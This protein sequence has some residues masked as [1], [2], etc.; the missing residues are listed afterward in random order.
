M[1]SIPAGE[2]GTQRQE[3]AGWFQ[4]RKFNTLEL[5]LIFLSWILIAFVMVMTGFGVTRILKPLFHI[6]RETLALS[7]YEYFFFGFSI[8]SALAGVI[9]IFSS[10]GAPFFFVA[11]IFAL[12]F[13]IRWFRDCTKFIKQLF[14]GSFEDRSEKVIIPIALILVLSAAAH[15]ITLYDSGLYHEQTIK[16]IRNYPVIPGLGNIHGRLAFNSMFFVISAAFTIDYKDI[17]FYPLNSLCFLMLVRKLYTLYKKYRTSG[18][19]WVSFFFIMSILLSFVILLPDF[20]SPS[21]D[22][23]VAILIIYVFSLLLDSSTD[24]KEYPGIFRFSLIYILILNAVLYKLSSV[25]LVLVFIPVFR[26]FS[27]KKFLI[28]LFT[29]CI[30]VLP[31]LIRN[32]YL[33]GYLIYPFPSIDIFN[34]DWKIPLQNVIDEKLSIEN[35]AKIR[36]VPYQEVMG[37]KISEWGAVWLKS[38]NAEKIGMLVPNVLSIPIIVMMLIKKDYFPAAI[39]FLILINLVFWFLNA[40]DPRFVFGFLITGSSLV[41]SWF[42]FRIVKLPLSSLKTGITGSILIFIF[43]L[44]IFQNRKFPADA[45]KNNLFIFPARQMTAKTNEYRTNY[46]YKVPEEGDQCFNSDIPCQPYSFDNVVMIG[47]NVKSGFKTIDSKNN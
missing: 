13:L 37:M 6:E 12:I 47:D 41:L 40:P 22:I 24:D 25:L 3:P 34:V 35:W 10:I 26:K 30:L 11:F 44:V 17:L 29:T 46:T 36:G 32:Y 21:P 16:W 45:F 14:Y 1:C 42:L 5:L 23:I 7:F 33:S 4:D 9:S 39:L 19:A 8:L 27:L 15:I 38:L 31:F 43:I 18:T 2:C 20:N 28:A